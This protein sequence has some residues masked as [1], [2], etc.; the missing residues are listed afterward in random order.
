MPY[1]QLEQYLH[2]HIPLSKAMAVSVVSMAEDEV[3]LRAPLKPNINHR[4]TVFGGSASALAILAAWSLLYTR[5]RSAGI[6][7]RVV[8]QRNSV[9]YERPIDG[10]F[11]ARSS[12]ERP[13]DWPRFTRMLMRK[14]KARIAV[15]AVLEYEGQVVGRFTGEFVAL[16]GEGPGHE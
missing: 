3:V 12:I 11:T 10:E 6:D 9:E 8:I 13:Q 16:G 1:T 14:G 5:L 15:G 2:E 4:E 7:S